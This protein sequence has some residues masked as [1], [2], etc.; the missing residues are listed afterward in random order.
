MTPAGPG[1]LA[2]GALGVLLLWSVGARRRIRRSRLAACDAFPALERIL[3]AQ[4]RW[5][6][7]WCSTFRAGT[8]PAPACDAWIRRLAASARQASLALRRL[9]RDP[10]DAAAMAGLGQARQT[11][12]AVLLGGAVHVAATGQPFAPPRA[13]PPAEWVK[14]VHQEAP[15]AAQFNGHVAA[16]NAAVSQFPALLLAA[17]LRHREARAMAVLDP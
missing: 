3:S 6:G 10:L 14:L 4:H 15:L 1:L 13:W 12:R 17:V 7:D 16:Y 8:R 5:I 11:L 9:R 2:A